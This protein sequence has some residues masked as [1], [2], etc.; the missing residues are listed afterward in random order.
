VWWLL[1]PVV[2]VVVAVVA[3]GCADNEPGGLVADRSVTLGAPRPGDRVDNPVTISWE[4]DF[5][6]GEASGRWFVVHLDTAMVAPRASII[7][8]AGA[9]CPDVP[10]CIEQG[11]IFDHGIFLTDQR[12][13]DV[14]DLFPGEHR[15]PVLLVNREGIRETDSAWNA[16]F[17]VPRT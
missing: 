13:I 17:T 16:R 9:T 15:Y 11:Q 10:T 1:A 8:H 7:E 2:L 12:S 6:P 3:S 5:E 4:S 14:G